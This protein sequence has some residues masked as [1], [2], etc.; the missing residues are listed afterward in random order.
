MVETLEG[1][2]VTHCF[3]VP[4]ESF[5]GLL[6]AFYDSSI[7]VISTRH[8]GG[9]SFM[10]SGFAKI[11]GQIAVCFGT[12][13]VGATNLAIGVHTARQDSTPMIAF[14][15]QVNRSFAGREAFQETDLV[16][17]MRPLAKWATQI[18]S[19]DLA[20][21]TIARAVNIATTG[22]PGPVFISV[23]QD[24]CD[25]L[26]Q[27]SAWKPTPVGLPHPQ[28]EGVGIILEALLNASNP[29]IFAGGGLYNSPGALA[30]LVAFAEAAE[31]PV[32]TGW[33]HHDEF[34]N[35]HRLFLG[36]ASL[37]TS[38]AVW[39]RLDET[40]VVLVI[41]NR[42]QELTTD[43]YRFPLPETR[44]FQVDIDPAVLVSHRAPEFA[45]QADAGATLVAM[46]NR[47]PQP[48]PGAGA[49]R[50][51]NAADRRRYELATQ[52]P[53]TDGS[54]A[55]VSY[56]Q[57]MRA[58]AEVLGPEV[59][60]A[61]DA[62]NFYGWLATYHRFRRPHTYVGPA[63]GAM[64]Y[65]L[66]SA[67]G[68][69]IARPDLPVVSLSGDGGFIMTLAEIE[70]AVR[71]DAN[72]VAIVLDNERQGTIRMHQE[73]RHPGRVIGTDLGS[74]DF[75]LVARGLGAVGYLVT[76]DAEFG[77]ALTAALESGSM[78]VIHVRM[79]REQLS[80]R[81][82]LKSSDPVLSKRTHS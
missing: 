35:D 38:P 15:G 30:G 77:P 10:A 72:V 61:S 4:G 54:G 62:G 45:L 42:L 52:L 70:T 12:R 26:C 23:P 57:V 74:I 60:I 27:I 55:G 20:A 41:G 67:I 82:R 46:M 78:S 7:Q 11:S 33:R 63:S 17:M 47:L 69:K 44:L 76:D 25:E 6:D 75:S 73:A 24:V 14:A 1:A 68:A 19:A 37:G 58:L 59:I 18:P 31:I 51:R 29:L 28:P 34:P 2:G 48:V 80:V 9:G 53:D 64:G 3:G 32:I 71:Y 39:E 50:E 8:E 56:E 49:R 65:G 81:S 43:G 79:D 16:A 66:P 5:L 36:S 40:D 22:R 21:E 13:A